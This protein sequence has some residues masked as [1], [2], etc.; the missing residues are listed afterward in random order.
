[1]KL[2]RQSLFPALLLTLGLSVFDMSAWADVMPKNYSGT[3][4]EHFKDGGIKSEAKY[5]NGKKMGISILWYKPGCP[6]SVHFFKDDVLNGPMIKWE[7]CEDIVAIG[8]YKDNRPW[9]GFFLVNPSNAYPITST[10]VHVSGFPYYVMEYTDGI[11]YKTLS[12]KM[13]DRELDSN[14]IFRK[15]IKRL[16]SK[17]NKN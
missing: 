11:P 3:W 4:T 12:K 8:E 5:K 9:S 10:T 17:K 1:M 2:R 15:L 14:P 16:N 13:L 6:M 7:E